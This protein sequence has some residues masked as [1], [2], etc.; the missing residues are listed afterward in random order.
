MSK[1]EFINVSVPANRAS[2]L[3]ALSDA[4]EA[5]WEVVGALLDVFELPLDV[6]D[7]AILSLLAVRA[8]QALPGV[9]RILRPA[10]RLW[11]RQAAEARS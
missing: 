6:Q 1:N 2:F 8:P 10:A 5:T 4:D 7:S 9:F 3:E 11:P